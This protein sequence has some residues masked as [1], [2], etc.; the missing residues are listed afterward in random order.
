MTT[1]N[2]PPPSFYQNK[3]NY[4]SEWSEYQN[5]LQA[6]QLTSLTIFD[7]A[8]GSNEILIGCTSTGELCFFR[9]AHIAVD[10]EE[11]SSDDATYP[12]N[13]LKD[14]KTCFYRFQLTKGSLYSLKMQRDTEHTWLIVGGDG[15]VWLLDWNDVQD[16]L[17]NSSTLPPKHHHFPLHPSPHETAI[18][19]NDTCFQNGCLF[20]A[21][22]D[23][24]GCY[25]WDVAIGKLITTYP[26]KFLQTLTLVPNTNLL[27]TGGEEGVLNLWDTQQDHRVDQLEI[28]VPSSNASTNPIEKRGA[29]PINFQTRL[30]CSIAR[31]ENWWIIGGERSHARNLRQQSVSDKSGFLATFHG[32]TRS[33]VSQLE[34]RETPQKLA[35]GDNNKNILISVANESYVS[36]FQ[37]P[38]ALENPE[39]VWCHAPSVFAAAV[40]EQGILAV[41]GVGSTIDLYRNQTELIQTLRL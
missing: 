30:T 28:P 2:L 38:L 4:A 9:L 6:Q 15:G 26:S 16:A 27:L 35:F 34:L 25:K 3:L 40:S 20:G 10:D 32:P 21:A 22:G 5:Q 29:L 24:F 11:D 18:E 33:I 7:L 8:F 12:D 23:D 36:H 31:D 13:S 39:R 37:N 1:L 19:V 17:N 41:A 14:T